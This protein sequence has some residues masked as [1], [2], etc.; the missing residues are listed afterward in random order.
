MLRRC[1]AILTYHS[2][3]RSGSV[4]SVR[5]EV[6][7]RHMEM[8]QENGI[9][10]VP[11]VRI[12]ESPGAVALT[13][14]DGFRNFLEHAM[15]V[16]ETHRFPATVFVVSGHCGRRNDWAGQAR[17]TPQL[18]LMSWSELRAIA[19]RSIEIGAHTANHPDLTKLSE[20]AADR[21]LAGCRAAIE[22]E[23]GVPVDS[24]AYPY[25]AVNDAIRRAAQRHFA[26]ACGTRLDFVGP[27][28][29]P[30]ELPRLDAYY[31]QR[32]LWFDHLMRPLGRGYVRVRSSLRRV[33]QCFR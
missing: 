13:F 25:G 15:P 2:L 32:L 33:R 23:A 31:L 16:L 26:H 17:D 1:S 24:F 30:A 4:I 18:D 5:P 9:P 12:R 11:L 29:D 21:E 14:D 27:G 19:G 10:V 8:L 6:F 28:S 20:A 3:D 7:R 22:Q